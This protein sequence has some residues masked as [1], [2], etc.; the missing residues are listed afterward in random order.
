[1]SFEQIYFLIFALVL[2]IGVPLL[3]MAIESIEESI[4]N[5]KHKKKLQKRKA[6]QIR[7]NRIAKEIEKID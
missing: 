5:Y 4:R 2:L 3:A 1:M 7:F 6:D